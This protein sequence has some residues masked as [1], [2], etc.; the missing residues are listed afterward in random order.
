M[1]GLKYS[2]LGNFLVPNNQTVP[3][4][5]HLYAMQDIPKQHKL[6]VLI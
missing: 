6:G 3:I 5:I 2:M 4:Q 1:S